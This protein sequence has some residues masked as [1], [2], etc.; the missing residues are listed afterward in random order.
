[1]KPEYE[2]GF[3]V[4]NQP[5]VVL[6]ALDFDHRFVSMPLIGI[7]IQRRNELYRNIL[8]QRR[9]AGTPIADGGVGNP[10]IHGGLQD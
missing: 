7:E 9:K 2:A 4:H 6:H 3:S 1:M 5:E 10:D 8:K